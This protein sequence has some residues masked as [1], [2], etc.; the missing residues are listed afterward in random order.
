MAHL[1]LPHPRLQA[2]QYQCSAPRTVGAPQSQETACLL[3][4]VSMLSERQ[5]L[6]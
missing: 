5:V 6:E 2:D 4:V 3:A 1:L